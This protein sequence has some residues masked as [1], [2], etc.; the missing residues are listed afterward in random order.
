MNLC[1]LIDNIDAI[2]W[3]EIQLLTD[4]MTISGIDYSINDTSKIDDMVYVVNLGNAA[5]VEECY[6][7]LINDSIISSIIEKKVKLLFIYIGEFESHTFLV[8]SN[9]VF[10]EVF[11]KNMLLM[12]I[13]K[14]VND[15]AIP[16]EM[17]YVL[18]N[19]TNGIPRLNDS[20]YNTLNFSTAFK[21]TVLCK[22]SQKY[23]KKVDIDVN[24]IRKYRYISLNHGNRD[25][26]DRLINFL[27]ENNLLK[28][29]KVSY[30][31]PDKIGQRNCC[32]SSKDLSISITII[33]VN[34][35]R[36]LSTNMRVW[37]ENA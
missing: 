24:K 32:G 5:I 20:S 21:Y 33:I 3:D 26:R 37:T 31:K 34:M 23:I 18:A 1:Y 11:K 13:D 10:K 17:V 14:L 4:A 30:S 29:G 27:L 19:N 2:I 12:F 35:V 16:T 36:T 7:L 9:E 8:G 15:F 25:Y 28:L 22:N 6:P